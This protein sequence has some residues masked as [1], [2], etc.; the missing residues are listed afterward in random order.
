MIRIFNFVPL[1]HGS[2]TGK[3]DSIR[4]A[5]DG[6]ITEEQQQKM[7]IILC[8]YNEVKKC[9]VSLESL[10]LSLSEPYTRQC[11]LVSTVPG[12]KNPFSAIAIISEIGADMSVFYCSKTL[13]LLR[14][15]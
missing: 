7:N 12:I 13:M 6:M 15:G 10:I 11:S 14:Q 1:L 4:L 8:H 2:M 9:K 3:V 5:L